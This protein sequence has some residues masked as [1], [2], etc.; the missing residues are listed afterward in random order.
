MATSDA[1]RRSP[2][3]GRASGGLDVRL[4]LYR[5]AD[6]TEQNGRQRP[7][8]I[9]RFPHTLF[10]PSAWSPSL[11]GSLGLHECCEIIQFDGTLYIIDTSPDESTKVNGQHVPASPI[12]PGDRITLNTT[13]LLVS[14]ERMTSAPPLPGELVLSNA[15]GF[16]R[17]TRHPRTPA[18]IAAE[19]ADGQQCDG[20]LAR[21]RN[22]EA[23]VLV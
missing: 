17:D 6:G 15:L 1:C 23:K 2:V 22:D 18:L 16:V 20:Q 8:V 7:Y 5:F 4:R 13:D 9:D 11:N 19:V 3:R 14:Y 12:L 21:Q 10:D